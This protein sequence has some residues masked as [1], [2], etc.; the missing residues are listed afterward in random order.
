MCIFYI[1]HE[2]YHN[3]CPSDSLNTTTSGPICVATMALFHSSC[4]AVLGLHCGAQAPIAVACVL[5]STGCGR[6]GFRSCGSQALDR[7]PSSFGEFCCSKAHG[8]FLD[9]GS[10]PRLPHWRWI[11]IHCTIREG[12]FHLF[13]MTGTNQFLILVLHCLIRNPYLMPNPCPH[14]HLIFSLLIA[15]HSVHSLSSPTKDQTL[16]PCIELAKS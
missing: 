15:L 1:P 2:W 9:Q 5:G 8:I 7:R 11:L 16:A 14:S 13:F 10:N 3:T 4:L 12:L 6:T